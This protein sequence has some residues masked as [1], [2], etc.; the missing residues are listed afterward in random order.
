[1]LHPILLVDDL[2]IDIVSAVMS[3]W[4][5]SVDMLWH[6]NKS[7][8]AALGETCLTHREEVTK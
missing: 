1:V 6:S 2:V 5:M 7:V 8:A 3:Y 4:D